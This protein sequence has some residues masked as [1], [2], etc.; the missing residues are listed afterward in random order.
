MLSGFSIVGYGET[1]VSR[2]RVDKGE[3]K[4]SLQEYYAWAAELTLKD[5]GLEK[6]DFDGP[7]CIW[8]W[9]ANYH[10]SVAFCAI[11][12]WLGQ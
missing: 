11:T 4:L 3:Q 10:V 7:P 12:Q 1:P 8:R 9:H 2:A 6:K 5:A